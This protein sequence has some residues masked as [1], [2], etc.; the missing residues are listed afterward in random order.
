MIQIPQFKERLKLHEWLV[1]NKHL[2][3]D[4]KKSEMKKADACSGLLILSQG[5]TI[6]SGAV[7]TGDAESI[8]VV[9]IINTTKLFDSHGDVHF[10]GLWTKS[11]KENKNNYLVKEHEFT[12]DGTI[13]DQVKVSTQEYTWKEL[14]FD[15]EGKTQALVYT[16]TITKDDPTGMFARYAKGQVKQHSVGMRYVKL[17]MAVDNKRYPEEQKVWKDYFDLIANKAE[18]EKAGYFWAVT[19]AKNIEGSAVMRGSNF[20]TPTISVTG[21]EE[22]EQ[23]TPKSLYALNLKPASRSIYKLKI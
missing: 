11:I 19:E 5:E 20:A 2:L 10:D 1:A 16:S 22:P 15:Y 9:S 13:T 14:G 6:K 8:E 23:S 18:V 4:Q 12:F 21:K 17:A 7:V 3:I